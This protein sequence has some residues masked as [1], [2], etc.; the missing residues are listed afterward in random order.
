M[1]TF[2]ALFIYIAEDNPKLNNE[3]TL[4]ASGPLPLPARDI[5]CDGTPV[6]IQLTADLRI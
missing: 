6:V 4:I 3:D 1:I 2:T 5:L